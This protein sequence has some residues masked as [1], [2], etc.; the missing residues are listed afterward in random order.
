M[1][2]VHW[3]GPRWQRQQPTLHTSKC[4]FWP[5]VRSCACEDTELLL[6]C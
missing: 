3:A 1:V 4:D 2:L 6:D 5:T